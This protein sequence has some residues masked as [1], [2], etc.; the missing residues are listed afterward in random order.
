MDQLAVRGTRL[1]AHLRTLEDE[2][3]DA[4]RARDEVI[5]EME[6]A[7]WTYLR[8]AKTVGLSVAQV[9]RILINETARQQAKSIDPR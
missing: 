5:A 8:I 7:G 9:G 6:D 2:V 4:R 3:S 1:Q